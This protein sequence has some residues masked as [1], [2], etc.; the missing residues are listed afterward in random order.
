M[1]GLPLSLVTI[2]TLFGGKHSLHVNWSIAT[3]RISA[4]LVAPLIFA[5]L[6]ITYNFR[7]L[8]ASTYFVHT[9]QFHAQDLLYARLQET[10]LNGSGTAWF[11]PVL[12]VAGPLARDYLFGNTRGAMTNYI[13][14][15]AKLLE[16]NGRFDP[17]C[18]FRGQQ[19]LGFG[20]SSDYYKLILSAH[21]Y[22]HA[23]KQTIKHTNIYL[24]TLDAST[25]KN[26][27]LKFW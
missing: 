22:T 14:R 6:G 16:M 11:I 12:I 21:A 3:S 25:L 18:P 4:F 17:V 15:P 13:S 19:C 2:E 27:V 10:L 24:L 1:K 20:L 23:H 8:Y 5:F 7:K 26:V 9:Q